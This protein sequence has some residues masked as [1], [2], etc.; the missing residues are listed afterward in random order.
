M[1]AQK[2]TWEPGD[3]I[4]TLCPICE[5]LTQKILLAASADELDAAEQAYDEHAQTHD[6][7]RQPTVNGYRV[8]TNDPPD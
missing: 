1:N 4:V 8:L 6:E 3:V 7:R 2:F 5:A